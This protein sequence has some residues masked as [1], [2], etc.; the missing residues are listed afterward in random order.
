MVSAADTAQTQV[1]NQPSSPG[2]GTSLQS[3]AAAKTKTAKEKEK[4]KEREKDK[5]KDREKEKDK[6]SSV[7]FNPE[8]E[9]LKEALEMASHLAIDRVLFVFDV[10]PPF[11]DLKKKRSV[12]KKLVVATPSEKIGARCEEEGIVHEIIPAYAF[13]RFD[14]IKISVAACVTSNLLTDGM[15][16]LCIAG[17]L[18]TAN[19]DTCMLTRIGDHSEESSALGVLQAGSEFSAQ[20]LECVLNLALNIG[21]EG[22]EGSPVGTIFVVGDSVA[23]M[24]KSKQLTLNPFQ[25]Y[26]EA[27]KNILDPK[28]RDAIRNYALLD[29]AIIVREDGVVLAAGRYL[30]ASEDLEIELPLGLGARNAAALFITKDTKAI[31]FLVSKTNGAIRIFK[32]GML[33][34]EFKQP[35][36]RTL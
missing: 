14:K 2:Q 26:S 12:R 7:K 10:M 21:Y 36:R 5:D 3:T 16:V 27:E 20:V 17:K 9:F 23:V 24:E 11:E 18:N 8:K 34:V 22:F 19:M 31:T 30:R 6:P 32:D 4:D 15:T 35:H 1:S 25:G 33:A 13:D 28:V 29:G